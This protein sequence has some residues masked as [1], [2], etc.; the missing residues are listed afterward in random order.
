MLNNFESVFRILKAKFLNHIYKKKK[1]L[2]FFTC[3]EKNIPEN[4]FN[5]ET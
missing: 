2:I 4:D 1:E 3:I 5:L